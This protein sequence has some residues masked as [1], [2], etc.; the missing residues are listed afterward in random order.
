MTLRPELQNF[1]EESKLYRLGVQGKPP[2]VHCKWLEEV[3]RKF[4]GLGCRL[5]RGG[6]RLVL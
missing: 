2:E 3:Q 4:A 1:R 6:V 5:G